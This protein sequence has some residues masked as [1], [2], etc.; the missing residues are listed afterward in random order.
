MEPFDSAELIASLL[1]LKAVLAILASFLF[2]YYWHHWKKA[3]KY[4]AVHFFYAK[5]RS[6]GHAALVGLSAISFAV[7]FSLELFGT[8]LGLSANAARALS[9]LLE[10]GAL[11]FLLFMFFQLS[12]AD[13]P[14]FQHIFQSAHQRHH[15]ARHASGEAKGLQHE[16]RKVKRKKG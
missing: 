13:V 11:L 2:F 16:G 10:A 4:L 7:G 9:S 14:H 5:W 8:S 1:L 15:H 6:V 3:K 12:L